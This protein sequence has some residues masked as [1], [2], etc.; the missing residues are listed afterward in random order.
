M[1]GGISLLEIALLL[2]RL[3]GARWSEPWVD[4]GGAAAS[5]FDYSTTAIGLITAPFAASAPA[6]AWLVWAAL[7]IGL[8]VP[9]TFGFEALLARLLRGR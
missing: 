1:V 9:L 7:A 8:A 6:V 4:G 3:Q 2:R 5:A